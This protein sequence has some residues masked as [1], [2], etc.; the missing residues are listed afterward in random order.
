M[1]EKL[2]KAVIRLLNFFSLKSLVA[3]VIVFSSILALSAVVVWSIT[4]NLRQIEQQ[5]LSNELGRVE[6]AISERMAFYFASLYAMRAFVLQ[7]ESLRPQEFYSYA[8]ELGFLKRF[9]RTVGIGYA[10]AFDSKDVGLIERSMREAGDRNFR[11]WPL[12]A[13]RGERKTAILYLY[14]DN[15]RNRRALGFDMS[16]EDR[17]WHAMELAIQSGGLAI[18]QPV[19]LVQESEG[20][21]YQSF[22]IYLPIF[23]AD[24]SLRGF[25]YTHF[26]A[27][28]LFTSI[29]GRPQEEH[30]SINYT[31]AS[32]RVQA[33]SPDEI[34]YRRFQSEN[35]TPH[36]LPRIYGNLKSRGVI[37][38]ENTE[39]IVE[40]WPRHSMLTTAESEMLKLAWLFVFLM[41]ALTFFILRKTQVYFKEEEARKKSLHD[42]SQ[43]KSY[44]LANMSHEIRT[45]LSAL[46]G[47][48]DALC[49]D[50]IS[51]DQRQHFKE[52]IHKNSAMLTRII[53]DIL[54]ISKVEAGKLHIDSHTISLPALLAEIETLMGFQAYQKGKIQ[55]YIE[56]EGS[57]PESFRTDDARLKQILMNLIGNAIKFTEKGEIR[58]AIRKSSQKDCLIF[59]VEDTGTGIPEDVKRSL[60]DYFS[61]GDPTTTRRY[62]GTGLGLKLSQKIAQSLGGNVVLL[63]SEVGVGSTFRLSHPIDL[64]VETRMLQDWRLGVDTSVKPIRKREE[65]TK[66]LLAGREILLVE[67]SIDNQ[68]IFTIFLESAGAKVSL[69]SDGSQ[70]IE[71]ALRHDYDLILMDIQ[72]PLVNGKDAT[73]TLRSK[74]YEG[75]IVA[76]T[77]HALLE[78]KTSCLEAGCNG[79]ITKPTTGE[80]LVQQAHL[81]IAESK[82]RGHRVG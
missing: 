55:F 75:L 44:F 61:Q 63:K 4:N 56:N 72:I 1:F 77:A 39:W 50:A 57:I 59:D 60:F 9:P 27:S 5:R 62:G 34:V 54:D 15:P 80:N 78:E 11:V 23:R 52:I 49:N 18:S 48:S 14:P 26:R 79:L 3:Q 17:R 7:K 45:P 73:R 33:D 21:S 66:A 37:S 29:L 46:V 51:Q 6:K 69:A 16:S 13:L 58:L 10:H 30:E 74:G 32:S 25:V 53:D 20:S 43:A 12:H 81:F 67:D 38:L 41:L 47:F 2:Q 68:E 22:L 8:D 65:T 70:A 71:M 24:K 31:I 35:T 19:S 42:A 82:H 28:D 36:R 64:K 76:L 40:A